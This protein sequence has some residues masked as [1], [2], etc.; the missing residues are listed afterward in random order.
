MLVYSLLLFLFSIS[1]SCLSSALPGQITTNPRNA[2]TSHNVMVVDLDVGLPPADLGFEVSFNDGVRIDTLQAENVFIELMVRLAR[3]NGQE[4]VQAST[5]RTPNYP[6]V[7]IVVERETGQE[8]KVVHFLWILHDLHVT[9]V[10][11]KGAH[12]VSALSTAYLHDHVVAYVAI[13]PNRRNLQ[14]ESAGENAFN[15]SAAYGEPTG[16]PQFSKRIG[17]MV[18]VEPSS[19]LFNLTDQSDSLMRR[20]LVTAITYTSGI[21]L[22]EQNM[23]LM[24]NNAILALADTN[25]FQSRALFRIRNSHYGIEFH[26]LPP[27][28]PRAR[29]PMNTKDDSLEVIARMA[30]YTAQQRRF[31]EIVALATVNRIIISTTALIRG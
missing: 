11:Q 29:P 28:P 2:M 6:D 13:G 7:A 20:N 19:S 5:Y 22:G 10:H 17:T 8:F 18:G 16:R 4:D 9:M 14:S 15:A 30:A 1:F 27:N 25:P 23:Y 21:D 24:Y 12:F 26:I 3:R 31:T